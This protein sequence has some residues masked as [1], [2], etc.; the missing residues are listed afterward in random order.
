MHS[1][2]LKNLDVYRLRKFDNV[3][4]TEDSFLLYYFGYFDTKTFQQTLGKIYGTKMH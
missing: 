3:V 1:S 2:C 4:K